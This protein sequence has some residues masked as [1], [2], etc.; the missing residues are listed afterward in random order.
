MDKN[1]LSRPG[2]VFAAFVGV[3]FTAAAVYATLFAY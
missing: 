2:L 1:W 3:W